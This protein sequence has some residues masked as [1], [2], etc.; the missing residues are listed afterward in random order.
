MRISRFVTVRNI[1]RIV[2]FGGI[3][4]CLLFFKDCFC[5]PSVTVSEFNANEVTLNSEIKV[6]FATVDYG[7]EGKIE[8]CPLV[9][10][11]FT[12][13]I[14]TMPA[15]FFGGATLSLT[16]TH[17]LMDVGLDL[18]QGDKLFGDDVTA[19]K[20][21]KKD[22][23]IYRFDVKNWPG[24]HSLNLPNVQGFPEKSSNF[25][26]ENISYEQYKAYVQQACEEQLAATIQEE[27]EF[28]RASYGV[29]IENIAKSVLQ[30]LDPKKVVV[31][32]FFIGGQRFSDPP[33]KKS[34][35]KKIPINKTEYKESA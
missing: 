19:S 23:V 31:V 3:L 14:D 7:C 12:G 2:V 28:F 17:V 21:E 15:W 6:T 24:V 13:N 32:R 35:L 10:N 16:N 1:M 29:A 27:N 4:L 33:Q 5:T 30:P 8:R 26:S 11:V 9:K 34:I 20:T 25:F 18:K 22:S